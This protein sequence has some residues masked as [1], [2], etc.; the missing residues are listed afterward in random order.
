MVNQWFCFVFCICII[1]VFGVCKHLNCTK[2][3]YVVTVAAALQVSVHTP[4]F[5]PKLIYKT[6]NYLITWKEV[7]SVGVWTEG[8]VI[9]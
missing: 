5:K 9:I 7:R 4:F 8:A 2:A 3:V 1:L 6:S